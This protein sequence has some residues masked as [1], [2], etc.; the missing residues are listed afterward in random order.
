MDDHDPSSTFRIGL[1]TQPDC[2]QLFQG[3]AC[4]CCSEQIIHESDDWQH[5]NVCHGST[6]DT[7]G[8]IWGKYGLDGAKLSDGKLYVT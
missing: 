1:Q 2:A 7:E 3:R 6:P 5:V 8:L 4:T